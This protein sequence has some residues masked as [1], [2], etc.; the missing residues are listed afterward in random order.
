MTDVRIKSVVILGQELHDRMHALKPGTAMRLDSQ[1]REF[2]LLAWE[3]YE[4]ILSLAGLSA[5]KVSDG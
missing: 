4:H 3:D 2:A 5:D 1:G